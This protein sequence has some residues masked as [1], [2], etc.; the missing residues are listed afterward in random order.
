MPADS[1][2]VAYVSPK[3]HM[4]IVASWDTVKTEPPAVLDVLPLTAPCGDMC[5]S[6]DCGGPF[7]ARGL[8]LPVD[9]P[10]VVPLIDVQRTSTATSDAAGQGPHRGQRH[11]IGHG[12]PL[13][14]IGLTHAATPSH[15]ARES[16]VLLRTAH[17]RYANGQY[18]E[19][20]ALCQQVHQMTDPHGDG[21]RDLNSATN[22]ESHVDNLL[23]LGAIH[24]QVCMKSSG[25]VSTHR[26]RHRHAR[27]RQHKDSTAY[28]AHA[29]HPHTCT[30][31]H[32]HT[33]T[34]TCPN[35]CGHTRPPPSSRHTAHRSLPMLVC[36]TD[37]AGSSSRRC[38]AA[39]APSPPHEHTRTRNMKHA[40]RG[41]HTRVHARCRRGVH[42]LTRP[43]GTAAEPA[44]LCALQQPRARAQARPHR[45][46][47]V[48][49]HIV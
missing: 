38:R 25:H 6:A 48:Y 42:A 30:Y 29:A 46:T 1:P 24:Y 47:R 26:H 13:H 12:R 39:P 44:R 21:A 18:T 7:G 33:P 14:D 3:Q 40:V 8:S 4:G 9:F 10:S 22:H 34:H 16:D 43:G 28:T 19:A 2:A 31:A 17:E 11:N 35:P 15:S 49:A 45:G 32:S 27:T 23:L 20:L 36:L 41:K 5:S 37:E